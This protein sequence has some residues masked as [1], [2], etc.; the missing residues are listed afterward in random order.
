MKVTFWK[1]YGVDAGDAGAAA[2]Q[3]DDT[4]SDNANDREA[5]SRKRVFLIG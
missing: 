1:R 3:V 4:H 5:T 2:W